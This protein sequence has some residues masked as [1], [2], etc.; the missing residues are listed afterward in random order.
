MVSHSEVDPRD[1]WIR[2]VHLSGQ[3]YWYNPRIFAITD[4][5]MKDE[6]LLNE[7]HEIYEIIMEK[8]GQRLGELAGDFEL[9]ITVLESKNEVDGS[10][11]TEAFFSA[12]SYRERCRY[13]QM[14]EGKDCLFP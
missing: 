4:Q 2:Y 13:S 12:Y 8:H 14:E 9:H 10:R 5:N 6:F 7:A 11:C 3:V 1:S